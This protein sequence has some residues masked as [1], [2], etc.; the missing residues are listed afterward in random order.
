MFCYRCC[1]VAERWQAPAVT[2]DTCNRLNH[3]FHPEISIVTTSRIARPPAM[4][5][6]ASWHGTVQKAKRTPGHFRQIEKWHQRVK[7]LG[8][9]PS[10]RSTGTKDTCSLFL[11]PPFYS[12]CCKSHL[13]SPSSSLRPR[14]LCQRLAFHRPLLLVFNRRM[15]TR[16]S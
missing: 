8:I 13:S 14:R 6:A 15:L 10:K 3:P 2:I 12:T 4:A 11:Y 7:D 9:N 16:L 5:V 1:W